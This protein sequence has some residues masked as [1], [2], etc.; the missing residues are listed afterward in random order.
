[1]W[2]EHVQQSDVRRVRQGDVG[3]MWPACRG[4][5][6]GRAGR[7]TLPRPRPHRGRV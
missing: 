7:G 1:M 2:S 6:V 4:C 5:A 3:R